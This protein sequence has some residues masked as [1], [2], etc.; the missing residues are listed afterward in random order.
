MPVIA[1]F[2]AGPVEMHLDEIVY[3]LRDW[4]S[5]RSQEIIYSAVRRA[6]ADVERNVHDDSSR[7]GGSIVFV[8]WRL[9]LYPGR[10]VHALYAVYHHGTCITKLRIPRER[11][12]GVSHLVLVAVTRGAHGSG[13]SIERFQRVEEQLPVFVRQLP[14][15]PPHVLD[16]SRPG[17][18]R[19]VKFRPGQSRPCRSFQA[20]PGQASHVQ[21]RVKPRPTPPKFRNS[22]FYSGCC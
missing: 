3:A 19:P 1:V 8:V 5:T 12:T 11:V 6:N 16:G 2:H 22:Q 18:A 10:H 21:S 9:R 15:L 20:R 14:D 4:N 7:E 17:Q 13:Q